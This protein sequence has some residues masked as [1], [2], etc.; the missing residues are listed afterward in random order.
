M[1]WISL[2]C[3][4]WTLVAYGISKW[5]Y[6]R[7]K[8][9]LLSPAIIAPVAILLP[10]L[11]F[12]IHYGQYIGDTRWL[13]WLLGPATVAFAVPIYN[14]RQVAKRHWLALSLGMIVGLMVALFSAAYLAKLFEFNREVSLSLMARSVSTPFAV[15][16]VAATGGSVELVSLFTVITGL[17]GMIAG[18]FVLAVLRLRSTVAHGASFGVSAHGFGTARARERGTE[19]GVV[20]S[21]T[22]VFSGIL[23]VLFG[24]HLTGLVLSLIG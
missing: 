9:V 10:L 21:L 5:A 1:S 6:Q 8:I 12:H 2:L 24:P 15:E 7:H 4:G 20:A 14:H 22:M 13:T 11:A 23:M 16:V 18:D 3:F 19:E 17:V